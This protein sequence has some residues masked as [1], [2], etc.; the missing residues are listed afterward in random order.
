MRQPI[1]K[2]VLVLISVIFS[3]SRMERKSTAT[4]QT[5]KMSAAAAEHSAYFGG[6]HVAATTRRYSRYRDNDPHDLITS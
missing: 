4:P 5:G 3:K 1:T 6:S 2:I